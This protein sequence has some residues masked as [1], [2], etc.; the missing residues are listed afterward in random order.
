MDDQRTCGQGLAENAI[1]PAKLGAL[2][3]AMADVLETHI[4]ALDLNDAHARKERDAYREL[5]KAQRSIAAQL[6]AAAMKMSACKTLPM[7]KHD[8]KTMVGR[9]ALGS[10]KTFV[11]IEQEVATLLEERLEQDRQLLAMM[12]QARSPV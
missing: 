7:G 12:N 2:T 1:L 9:E 6:Q 11:A 8:P 4:K 10:F 5:S 3:A